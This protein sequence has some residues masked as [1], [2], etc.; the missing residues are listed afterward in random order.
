MVC[1]RAVMLLD[2]LMDKTLL[3]RGWNTR[4]TVVN[5]EPK[6]PLVMIVSWDCGPNTTDEFSGSLG[7]T[8]WARAMWKGP[9]LFLSPNQVFGIWIW[10]S[11]HYRPRCTAHGSVHEPVCP[12][13]GRG[14]VRSVKA[15][16]PALA[17]WNSWMSV[18][19]RRAAPPRAS[20]Y[21]VLDTWTSR[22]INSSCQIQA[23]DE[24]RGEERQAARV[25]SPTVDP[26]LLCFRH[27]AGPQMFKQES[28][29]T[30]AFKQLIFYEGWQM[31]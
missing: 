6:Y 1:S 21:N 24:G 2:C 11:S 12:G 31:F 14:L 3:L 29:T 19:W 15:M 4:G 8:R 23:Q 10:W 30:P 7:K 9:S 20:V 13:G 22:A 26:H 25:P 27:P 5:G 17:N 16:G 18:T 28:W